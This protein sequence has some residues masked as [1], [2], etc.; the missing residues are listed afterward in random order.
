MC[1]MVREFKKSLWVH[2]KFSPP[3]ISTW[4]GLKVIQ[5]EFYS[6]NHNNNTNRVCVCVCTYVIIY[7]ETLTNF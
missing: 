6:C 1:V 5:V 3:A 7:V 4:Q 2:L